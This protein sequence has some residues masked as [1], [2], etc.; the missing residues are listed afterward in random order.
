MKVS[1]VVPA[2][3]EEQIIEKT[4]RKLET[5]LSI[6]HETV[7]VD[8]C[9]SDKTPE[10][11]EKLIEEF[12]NIRL[13]RRS[14]K[15]GFKEAVTAGFEKSTGDVVVP[16]MADL[17]DDVST[18][19]LMAQK[20]EEGYDVVCGSRH[21][22]GGRMIDPPFIQSFFSR[23]VGFLAF[24]VLGVPTRDV[25][26]AF[27]MYRK[28]VIN[29]ISIQGTAFDMS[30]ELCLKA[31]FKGYKIAEIPTTWKGRMVGESKF[32]VFHLAPRYWRWFA[33]GIMKRI[34]SKLGT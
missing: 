14:T 5:T 28:E 30:M 25:T 23:V 24:F 11:V 27:K 29:N 12:P 2:H 9:S 34:T 21:I 1:V 20:V 32:K 15:P 3:N 10:I 26:N 22:A 17:C 7:V 16:V 18:I 8:D 4:L 19:P 13:V 6:D 31:Y 33:W